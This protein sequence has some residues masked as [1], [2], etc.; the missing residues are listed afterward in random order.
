VHK[1]MESLQSCG[2]RAGVG[3]NSVC[4]LLLILFHLKVKKLIMI[5]YVYCLYKLF[6]CV[7]PQD[8]TTVTCTADMGL[9]SLGVVVGRQRAHLSKHGFCA[10]CACSVSQKGG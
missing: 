5:D 8:G 4:H 3:V 1:V 9:S 2:N 7:V 6:W 10:L